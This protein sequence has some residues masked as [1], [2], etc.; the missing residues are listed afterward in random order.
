MSTF[1]SSF[2]HTPKRHFLLILSLASLYIDV[3]P[4]SISIISAAKELFTTF[5]SALC[6]SFIILYDNIH[7]TLEYLI[8]IALPHGA[9]STKI[10][11]YAL[12]LFL[13][14]L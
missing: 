8:L 9:V 7:I 5:V 12:R 13:L 3:A 4:L 11:T 10:T 6:R 2:I 1:T 14:F